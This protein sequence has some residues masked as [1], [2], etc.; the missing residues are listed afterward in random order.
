MMDAIRLSGVGLVL[1]GATVLEGIE[2]AVGQTERVALLGASG[3]GKT[4]LLRLVAGL[5]RPDSGRI[6]VMGSPV[7][8]PGGGVSFVRQDSTLY[9]H[10]DVFDNLEFPLRV[11]QGSA[12]DSR[13]T[14]SRFGIAALLDRLP[15]TLSAGQRGVV[16]A[17]R[18]VVRDEVSVVLLDEPMAGT[19][20]HRRRRLVEAL[21]SDPRLTVLMAVNEPEDA[22]RWA[23]RVVVLVDGGIGQVGPP[24]HVFRHPDSLAV[25]SLLGEL[26][27]FPAVL[28]RG[29][30]WTVEIGGSRLRLDRVPVGAE[31]GQRVVV[32]VR[33]AELARASPAMPFDRVLR[34]TVGRVEPTGRT[35]RVLFGLGAGTG[36]GFV[37]EVPTE[38]G[39]V[40][41][42]TV[43]WFISPEHLR[44]YD[45]GTGWV[46]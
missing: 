5:D 29:Q 40:P 16:A 25:A 46:L 3:S 24:Q 33:P 41:G 34:G 6:E 18:A 20:P 4:S 9:D 11:S 21:M 7:A 45:P 39:V 38:R 17:A 28:R 26:N 27:R 43:D 35:R 37:A 14:A 12:G 44:L 15:A 36:V 32:G 30:G 13:G 1:G 2:L 31:D 10:L 8:G 42:D 19:D 22:F 23:A